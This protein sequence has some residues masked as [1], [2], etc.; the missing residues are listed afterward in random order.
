[1]TQTPEK[2][3][4]SRTN[5][6]TYSS[7]LAG[8]CRNTLQPVLHLE[9]SNSV[10]PDGLIPT[11]YEPHEA[12][13]RLSVFTRLMAWAL[14]WR[15]KSGELRKGPEVPLAGNRHVSAKSLRRE[16]ATLGIRP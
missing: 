14:D 1:M 15:T 8:D 10:P 16:G 12:K 5:R 11:G 7:D 13:P 6:G 3:T 4:T 9:T 2:R